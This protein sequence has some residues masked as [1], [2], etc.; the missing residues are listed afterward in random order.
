MSRQINKQIQWITND[1]SLT[2]DMDCKIN[3]TSYYFYGLNKKWGDVF[4]L[5]KNDR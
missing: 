4:S 3:I 2:E 1:N 5:N